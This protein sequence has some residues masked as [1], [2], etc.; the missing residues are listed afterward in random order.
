VT[1][2][3]K[4]TYINTTKPPTP[5]QKKEQK[6]DKLTKTKANENYTLL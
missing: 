4:I 3:S 2:N 6:I 5:G 1:I